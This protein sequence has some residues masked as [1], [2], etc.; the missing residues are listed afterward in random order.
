MRR[1]DREVTEISELLQIID[2]CRVCRVATQD[3]QGIYIIPMNFGYLYEEEKLTL[4]FHSARDGRKV[5]AFQV[6]GQAAFE[7][8][9]AHELV[10][11]GL[12]CEYGYRYK[13]IVGSGTI[14]VVED[15][16]YKKVALNQLMKQQAGIEAA[17][18]DRMLEAVL[19]YRLE[20]EWFSGKK[21]E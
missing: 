11:G 6:N 7:M 19:V 21:R 3:A 8:D 13:S 15:R 1:R 10:T 16:E 4:F 20:A 5:R 2:E 17:Y 9:C 14:R 12:A 18:D